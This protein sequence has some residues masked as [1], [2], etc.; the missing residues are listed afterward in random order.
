MRLFIPPVTGPTHDVGTDQ[1][2]HRIQD[3]RVAHQISQPF[4]QQVTLE[5]PITAQHAAVGEFGLLEVAAQSRSL[6]RIH[7]AN[8]I[9]KAVARKALNG[10]LIKN[11]WHALCPPGRRYF[12]R[13]DGSKHDCHETPHRPPVRR[14][15]HRSER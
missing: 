1:I 6:L 5:T 14:H 3:A 10:A 7:H 12:L 15:R 11:L 8:W 13:P 4:V 9:E 2:L